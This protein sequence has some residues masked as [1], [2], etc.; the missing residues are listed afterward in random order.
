MEKVPSVVNRYRKVK[1]N[2]VVLKMAEEE[3]WRRPTSQVDR[4]VDRQVAMAAGEP[5]L[6]R[7]LM[8]EERCYGKL[9]SVWPLHAYTGMPALSQISNKRK[10]SKKEGKKARSLI[11]F[12]HAGQS[13]IRI[14]L[15][16]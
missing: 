10:M 3:E 13:K 2:G 14:L 12:R 15:M 6:F 4:V 9:S 11:L 5:G 16:S 8:V 1:T 7:T